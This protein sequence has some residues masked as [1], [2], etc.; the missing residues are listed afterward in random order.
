M[1]NLPYLSASDIHREFQ[2]YPH[3][4]RSHYQA[5]RPF[6]YSIKG[7]PTQI[8]ATQND[9]FT[10]VSNGPEIGKWESN[11]NQEIFIPVSYTHLTLPTILR[12]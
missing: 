8:K 4:V 3:P 9:V 2:N 12:V 6:E 10:Y 1:S 11:P 7:G 5:I